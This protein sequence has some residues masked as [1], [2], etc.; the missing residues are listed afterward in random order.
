[1]PNLLLKP[2]GSQ[3]CRSWLPHSLCF[4][5]V[6]VLVWIDTLSVQ[7]TQYGLKWARRMILPDWTW[8]PTSEPRGTQHNVVHFFCVLQF[9]FCAPLQ[10]TCH[11]VHTISGKA[12]S[13]L[14]QKCLKLLAAWALPA[15]INCH[16]LE[17]KL[18]NRNKSKLELDT[19]T[20]HRIQLKFEFQQFEL[21]WSW[22]PQQYNILLPKWSLPKRKILL[23]MQASVLCN[24]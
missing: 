14:F 21:S 17:C 19:S 8:T 1:M 4:G 3:V 22:R 24:T 2:Q 5:S 16:I 12:I 18:I 11:C 13:H 15:I 10:K 7:C 6:S 9:H 23:G 20:T